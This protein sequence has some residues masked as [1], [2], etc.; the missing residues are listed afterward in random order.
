MT[1]LIS[2]DTWESIVGFLPW[3]GLILAGILGAVIVIV[4]Y[5]LILRV[6][7]FLGKFLDKILGMIDKTM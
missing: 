3:I 5:L 2:N 6:V 7:G 4:P 1:E